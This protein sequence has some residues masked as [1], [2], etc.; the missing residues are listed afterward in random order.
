M[1]K[2]LPCY[3]EFEV[4][5]QRPSLTTTILNPFEASSNDLKALHHF[6]IYC[7]LAVPIGNRVV[8]TTDIPQLAHRQPFLMNVILGLGLSHFS[9]LTKCDQSNQRALQYRSQALVG[10]RHH[11][12]VS[13]S[14]TPED[15]DAALAAMHA[16]TFQ[17]SHIP[18]ALGDY[19]M[20]LRGCILV[21]EHVRKAGLKTNFDLSP[22]RVH[23]RLAGTITTVLPEISCQDFIDEINEA[24]QL[25]NSRLEDPVDRAFLNAVR[26]I[27][28]RFQNAGS[29]GI[30]TAIDGY[31]RWYDLGYPYLERFLKADHYDSLIVLMHF[32]CVQLVFT[33][34]LPLTWWPK[35]VQNHPPGAPLTDTRQ[36]VESFYAVVVGKKDFG[37]D[38]PLSVVQQIPS[39]LEKTSKAN[40]ISQNLEE[41]IERAA[42]M[43]QY[44]HLVLGSILQGCTGI[45]TWLESIIQMK[46]IAAE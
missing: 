21:T 17:T 19:K 15:T 43:N 20:L 6:L 37:M 28:D 8:W 39:S 25:L 33:V 1:S 5:R 29:M 36:W 22:E 14:W 4:A 32:L 3:Y 13:Q 34:I 16:L 27:V 45:A 46:V 24:L 23:S 18:T 12:T 44:A 40:V 7:P 38:W 35:L 42:N 9:E 41:K 26:P 31:S 10:L 2:R 11:I 30:L